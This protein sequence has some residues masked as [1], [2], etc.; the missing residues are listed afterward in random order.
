MKIS[1]ELVNS[2]FKKRLNRCGN[3]NFSSYCTNGERE[4]DSFSDF[5]EVTNEVTCRMK[6]HSQ[7]EFDMK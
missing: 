6:I 3:K 7:V 1:Q 5:T 4:A 2:K